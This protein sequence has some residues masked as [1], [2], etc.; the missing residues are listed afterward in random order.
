MAHEFSEPG[1]TNRALD[2]A[3]TGIQLYFRAPP[4]LEAQQRRCSFKTT[5]PRGMYALPQSG[6]ASRR[7]TSTSYCSSTRSRLGSGG[8]ENGTAKRLRLRAHSTG[9]RNRTTIGVERYRWSHSY[10]KQLLGS[11]EVAGYEKRHTRAQLGIGQR[12]ISGSPNDYS[13]EQSE[14][15][16]DR[17]TVDRQQ[18]TWVSTNPWIKPGRGSGFRQEAILKNGAESD[19]CAAS[20]GPRTRKW[21]QMHQYN[22]GAPFERIAIHVAGPFPLSDQGNWYLLI[23][24]DYFTKWSEAYAVP[25]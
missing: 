15:R 25:N 13:S 12:T 5:M 20:R 11:M 16:T 1:R 23:A 19:T 4:R 7:K 6:D 24:M 22:A 8:A 21:G 2:S 3:L 14:G 9:S 10:V 17:Y 18:V